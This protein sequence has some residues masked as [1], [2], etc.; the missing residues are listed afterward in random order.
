MLSLPDVVEDLLHGIRLVADPQAQR[1]EQ[2]VAQARAT[3]Q[4]IC[5]E[6]A[7]AVAAAE[8]QQMPV[9]PEMAASAEP[10]QAAVVE[11]VLPTVQE[12]LVLVAMAAMV[13]Y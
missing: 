7:A 9:T 2:A 13:T 4:L 10:A 1:A 6:P 8:Q 5:L 11:V 3:P 12:I